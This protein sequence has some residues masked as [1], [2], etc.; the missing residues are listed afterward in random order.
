[1]NQ[2]VSYVEFNSPDLD[3]TTRFFGEV[4]GW[5]PQPFAAPDYLVAPHGD[6]PASTPA[7]WPHGTDSRGPFPLSASRTSTR[8]SPG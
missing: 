6:S 8:R 5:Q 3:V 7:S 4:F 1:M 2:P